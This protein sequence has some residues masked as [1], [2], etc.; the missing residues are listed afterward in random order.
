MARTRWGGS[1]PLQY[2]SRHLLAAVLLGRDPVF[3]APP[4]MDSNRTARLVWGHH[5]LLAAF[6]AEIVFYPAVVLFDDGVLFAQRESFPL[7]WKEDA[8]HIGMARELDAEHVEH[9]AFEPVGAS[10]DVHCGLR[11]F[12]IRD[13]GLYA[14]ALIAREAVYD[15][16][17]IEALGA[18]GIIHRR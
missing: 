3:R 15:V 2:L 7:F 1:S 13:H 5:R 4:G 10:V 11:S 14:D 17:Q 6:D 8:P 18:V 16:D 12:T 9:L